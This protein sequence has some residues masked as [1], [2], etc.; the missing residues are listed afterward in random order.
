[1]LL[2]GIYEQQAKLGAGTKAIQAAR[3][4]WRPIVD[5]TDVT[6]D[7]LL[8]YIQLLL[9]YVAP[10]DIVK[11]DEKN[12]ET[13][14]QVFA[15]DARLRIDAL[16]KL[17]AKEPR[18]E[19]TFVPMAL[20]MKLLSL[21]G[22]SPAALQ[23][24]NEFV[25]RKQPEAK[26]DA[27]RARLYLQ[28]GNL[29]GSV[30]EF[31]AAED[32]YRRVEEIAPTS[33]VLVAQSLLQQDKPDEAV[34]RCLQAAAAKP[35]PETALVLAQ[36]L[37][38]GK[39]V[40][41]ELDRQALRVIH[42]ALDDDRGNVDLLMSTAVLRVTRNE[43]D[44]AIRLFRR[45]V[46]LQPNHV[47]ALNNLATMLS[48]QQDSMSEAQQFIE[49]AIASAGRDPSLLDTLGTILLRSQQFK[50]AIAALEEA[51]AGTATDPRYYFHLAAAYDGDNRTADAQRA[52][53]TAIKLGLDRA[54]LTSGDR[55]L[56]ASLKQDLLTANYQD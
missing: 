9:R 38:S 19:T 11:G 15:D 27:D 4:T 51:V 54:I 21:Q 17:L 31:K 26:T 29:C 46:E 45:V 52:L 44:E 36:V 48:E 14:K 25:D 8:S 33:Y 56:L 6:A 49:R 39:K 24:L 37:S 32:W 55:E 23:L 50:P 1:M 22:E 10:Q 18:A 30:K 13:L 43:N 41:P 2:A 28:A 16:E 42:E 20:R 3:D 5:Q 53:Q 7:Q 12:A 40:D 47:L 34:K 35:S